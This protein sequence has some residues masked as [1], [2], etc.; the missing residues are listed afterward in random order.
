[1]SA[2]YK[3]ALLRT[4]LRIADAHS[5][6]VVDRSDGKVVIPL[7]L[8]GLYWIRQFKRLIDKENIQQNSNS[9]KGLGFIKPEGWGRLSH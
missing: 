8:V 5:G 7:G 4:L 2:T 3:L 1:K 6:A 9:S